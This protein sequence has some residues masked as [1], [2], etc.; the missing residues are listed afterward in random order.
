[1]LTAEQM[2]V[3]VTKLE[4]RIR[5]LQEYDVSTYHADRSNAQ[6]EALTTDIQSTLTDVFGVH[7]PEWNRFTSAAYFDTGPMSANVFGRGSDVHPQVRQQ[8]LRDSIE[9]NLATLQSAVKLLRERLE[10]SDPPQSK[11]QSQA[12]APSRRVFIVHGHDETT[13]QSVARFLEQMNFQAII[14]HE[15]PN[16]GRTIIEKIESNKDVGFAVV[17]LTPDDECV[18][19]TGNRKRARQ[20]VILELGYFIAHLGRQ[21]VVAMKKGDVE[22]PSDVMGVLY[23]DFDDR[24]AWKLDLAKELKA[25]GYAIEAI[26][27]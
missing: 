3:G 8:H 7:T 2:R 22:L 20:N 4:R 12:T 14:L 13:K 18:T 26:P 27:F 25:A 15:Q 23:T 6:L 17:L 1:M 10:H 11:S 21:R 9:T 16:Q 24:G 19:S 5:E